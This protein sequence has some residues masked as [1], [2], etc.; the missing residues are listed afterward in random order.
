MLNRKGHSLSVILLILAFF[1]WVLSVINAKG[2]LPTGMGELGLLSIL[3]ITFLI[4]FALLVLSFFITLQF[5]NGNHRFLLVCQT[6]LL[7]CF[8][9]LTPV[10]IEGT[11]RFT[12]G[13][14]NFV[15]VDYITQTG[16]IN[17]SAIWSNNWP[18]FS[19]FFSAISQL[20]SIPDQ[21]ILMI[22]PALFNFVLL[23]PVF[24]FFHITTKNSKQTWFA[25][26]FLFFGNWVGQDYFSMQSLAFFAI[27][28]ILFLA[29]KNI[30]KN[31]HNYQWFILFFF[32]LFFIT[33]S[34][35]LSSIAVLCIFIVFS[36]TRQLTRPTFLLLIA[37]LIVSWT[38]FNASTYLGWNLET[39]LG[40]MLDLGQ[41]FHSNIAGRV[42]GSPEHILISQVRV[43]FSAIIVLF[44]VL[45]FSLSFKNKQ[46]GPTEK[47]ILYVLIGFSFL[48]FAFTYG[49][50]LFMRLYWFTLIP[51]A[52]FASK[53]LKNKLV[54]CLIMIFFIIA[55]P[56]LHFV[57]HYGSE[58]IDYVPKSELEGISFFYD[59]TTQGYVIG[60]LRD[61]NYHH[62]YK[63]FSF[64]QTEWRNDTLTVG[65]IDDRN[66]NYSTYVVVSYDRISY[67]NYVLDDSEYFVKMTQNLEHSVY[68]SKLYS[69][70]SFNVYILAES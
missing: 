50:E 26:W 22:Y 12:M 60:P 5:S 7:I 61:L 68:Y 42:S 34:H 33:S 47:R 65:W 49:G 51:C 43:I 15:S 1:L 13:Y 28:L 4:A 70:P 36:I 54:L 14:Y 21:Y 46:F 32:I 62:S 48:F 18:S 69:N 3:P 52:F 10:I 55:A 30:D 39:I 57:S 11:A 66:W 45:G 31:M 9:N 20:C 59:M 2:L 38:V 35:L 56:S 53:C 19:I 8:L 37:V 17:P 24:L 58:I 16:Q 40:Q 41:I 64:N 27:I 25:I 23:I 63:V 44:A 67:Y 6:I 29:F